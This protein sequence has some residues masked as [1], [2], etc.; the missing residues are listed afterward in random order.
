M[1]KKS[2]SESDAKTKYC[3]HCGQQQTS[4]SKFCSSC[5]HN[6]S[7]IDTNDH[8]APQNSSKTHPAIWVVLAIVIGFVALGVISIMAAIV[9]VAIN[10]TKQ[11]GDARNAQR[12]SDVNTIINAIYQYAIDNNGDLPVE[13]PEVPKEICRSEAVNCMG[14][15]NLN[16]LIGDYLVAMPSDPATNDPRSTKY[17]IVYDSFGNITVDAPY[18]EGDV[19]ISVTR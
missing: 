13:L 3:P 6:L 8:A 5:G 16:D 18:A 14:L 15:V 12:A 1:P 7:E 10:P 2:T 17:T 19:D 9:I 4:N 11:L